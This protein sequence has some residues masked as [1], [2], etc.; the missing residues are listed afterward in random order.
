MIA[1]A[2][3]LIRS[4]RCHYAYDPTIMRGIQ[5]IIIHKGVFMP[6]TLA[7]L[8]KQ[9]A[10]L[11]VALDGKKDKKTAEQEMQKQ[12]QQIKVSTDK[13]IAQQ[14]EM[15]KKITD[16]AKLD[17]RFMVLETRLLKVEAEVKVAISLATSR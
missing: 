1:D 15:I 3:V 5:V 7:D 11:K 17:G 13:I 14:N 2:G 16:A 12:E 10:A 9:I 4:S 6:A 8:E